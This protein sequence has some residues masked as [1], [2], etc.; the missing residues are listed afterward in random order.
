MGWL[1]AGILV[2]AWLMTTHPDRVRSFGS[3]LGTGEAAPSRRLRGDALA[4]SE[5]TGCRSRTFLNLRLTRR[6]SATRHAVGRRCWSAA[7]SWR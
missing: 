5:R 2:L 3:I 7:S 1:G 6:R 4:A